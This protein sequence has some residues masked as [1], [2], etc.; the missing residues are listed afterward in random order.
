[1]VRADTGTAHKVSIVAAQ[2][3]LFK[4]GMGPLIFSITLNQHEAPRYTLGTN[5]ARLSMRKSPPFRLP[6]QASACK[7]PEIGF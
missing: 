4:T 2:N 5:L 1:M 6:R 7:R 3:N